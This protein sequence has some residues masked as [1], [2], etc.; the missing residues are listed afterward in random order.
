MAAITI[1]NDVGAQK[2]KVSTVSTVS[3]AIYHEVMGPDAMIFVFWMLNFKPTFSLTSF[4]FIKR[5]FSSSLSAIRMVSSVYL[6]LSIFSQESWFLEIY[7]YPS[8][9]SYQKPCSYSQSLSFCPTPYPYQIWQQTLWARHWKHI[10][11]QPFLGQFQSSS[12]HYH[13][14]LRFLQ[15]PPD[16]CSHSLDY[17]G[18]LLCPPPLES[19]PNTA[20][21]STLLKSN[22]DSS[23]PLLRPF[24]DPSTLTQSRSWRSSQGSPGPSWP[25]FSCFSFLLY[26]IPTRSPSFSLLQ[27]HWL[28]CCSSNTQLASASKV[29]HLPSLCR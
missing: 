24:S 16:F 9:G 26:S 8:S 27:P 25:S 6:R 3:P 7:K 15:E 4:T 10:Q 18:S 22:S 11:I 12:T 21:R 13:F 19:I 29:L 28:T 1:C 20:A 23:P 14:S 2:N 5:L 17:Y